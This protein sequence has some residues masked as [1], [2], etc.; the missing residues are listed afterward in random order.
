MFGIVAI[1]TPQGPRLEEKYSPIGFTLEVGDLQWEGFQSPHWC[2]TEYIDAYCHLNWH[3]IFIIWK[4]GN[5]IL[6][7]K[8]LLNASEWIH[9]MF[10]RSYVVNVLWTVWSD[11]RSVQQ[12]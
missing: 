5:M 3:S 10:A 4:F 9:E 6:L 8:N 12:M 1:E 2:V 7:K 11:L